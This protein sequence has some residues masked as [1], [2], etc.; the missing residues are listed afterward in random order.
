MKKVTATNIKTK[1]EIQFNSIFD[2]S[3]AL[4][5][6]R[7][8]ISKA[9]HKVINRAGNYH[10]D[11]TEQS[12]LKNSVNSGKLQ[13]DNPEL[14]LVNDIKVTRKVQRLTSEESTNKL[15]TSAEQLA[16]AS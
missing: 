12:V 5:I 2:A 13:K 11:F 1:E 3:I 10:W 6:D 16:I 9:L 4:K 8:C 15:D 7:T 14:S